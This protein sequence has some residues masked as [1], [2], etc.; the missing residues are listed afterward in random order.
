MAHDRPSPSHTPHLSKAP[1]SQHTPPASSSPSQH[2]PVRSTRVALPSHTPQASTLPDS[3]QPPEASMTAP[4][5]L[6]QHVPSVCRSPM[7]HAP[8]ASKKPWHD[9]RVLQ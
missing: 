9:L 5:V 8:V 6:S 2:R 4:K 3:Q 1:D 7:Q